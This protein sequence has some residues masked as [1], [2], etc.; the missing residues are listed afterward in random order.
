M[1][2]S[3]ASKSTILNSLP[4]Y[5]NLWDKSTYTSITNNGLV[6]N[7]DAGITSSYSGSGSTWTDLSGNS[8]NGS[9][10]NVTYSSTNGGHLVFNGSN[11]YVNCGNPSSLNISGPITINVIFNPSVWNTG[12]WYSLVTKGD[13]SYRVQNA[14]G[15]QGMDFGTTGLS[16]IDTVGYSLLD[17]NRWY[18]ATS[19]YDGTFK[20]IYVNSVLDKTTQV[21]GSLSTNSFN[22]YIGENSQ[23]TGRYF[24]GKIAAVQIYNTALTQDDINK[25][26]G[27]YRGRF[28]L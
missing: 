17:T 2:I 27:F 12:V 3:R 16:E 13:T 23:A 20:R 8:N 7:L 26:F 14:N 25:N 28:G 15:T 19:V 24:N 4:K 21:T 9:L 10:N 6:L 1:A 5:K 11:S 18:M 22:V